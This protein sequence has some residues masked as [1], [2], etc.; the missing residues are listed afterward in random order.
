MHIAQRVPCQKQKLG[1]KETVRNGFKINRNIRN[2]E[3]LFNELKVLD[4]NGEEFIPKKPG[5]YKRRLGLCMA[6]LTKTDICSNMIVLHSYLNYL[7]F[8]Q[9]LFYILICDFFSFRYH[10]LKVFYLCIK[11]TKRK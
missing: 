4:T 2:I 10:L 1:K 11:I 3:R 7:T 9:R 6:P 5:D 8:F